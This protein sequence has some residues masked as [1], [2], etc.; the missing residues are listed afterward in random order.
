MI[1]FVACFYAHSHGPVGYL[2]I[3]GGQF[4]ICYL[5]AF[6]DLSYMPVHMHRYPRY[7]SRPLCVIDFSIPGNPRYMALLLSTCGSSSAGVVLALWPND[8]RKTEPESVP[9]NLELWKE[10]AE[11]RITELVTH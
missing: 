10:D 6:L 1:L 2:L 3:K 5:R 8:T 4:S 11:A 9:A 7:I